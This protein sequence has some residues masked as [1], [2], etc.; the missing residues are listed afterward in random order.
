[1]CLLHLNTRPVGSTEISEKI[2]APAHMSLAENMLCP[3]TQQ[4][5]RRS[6]NC[7]KFYFSCRQAEPVV[8]WFVYKAKQTA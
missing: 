4:N 6:F 8:S 7:Q 5:R 3:R 1:M 2:R